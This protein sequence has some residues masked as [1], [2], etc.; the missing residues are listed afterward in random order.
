MLLLNANRKPYLGS[1]MHAGHTYNPNPDK[2]L[3]GQGREVICCTIKQTQKNERRFLL[4]GRSVCYD[5]VRLQKSAIH[6]TNNCR[7]AGRQGPRT[8]C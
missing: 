3:K 5:H 7:Q 4:W 1:Q 6:P 2:A 8:S